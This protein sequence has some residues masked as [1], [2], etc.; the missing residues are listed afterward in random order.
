MRTG[1]KW[2]RMKRFL[3]LEVDLF[4]TSPGPQVTCQYPRTRCI[5][6]SETNGSIMPP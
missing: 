2:V 4:R 1:S 3:A 6:R 5:C